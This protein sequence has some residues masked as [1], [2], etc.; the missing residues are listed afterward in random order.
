[1]FWLSISLHWFILLS[2]SCKTV[3]NRLVLYDDEDAA[4]M[5]QYGTITLFTSPAAHS[6]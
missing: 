6:L 4:R 5:Q 1:M 3:V 2:G